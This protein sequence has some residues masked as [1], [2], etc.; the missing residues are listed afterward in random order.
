MYFY[1]KQSHFKTLLSRFY[2]SKKLFPIDLDWYIP[3]E[4]LLPVGVYHCQTIY[5]RYLSIKKNRARAV[6]KKSYSLVWAEVDRL[7]FFTGFV[8]INFCKVNPSHHGSTC[9]FPDRFT[10]FHS[11]TATRNEVWTNIFPTEMT[12]SSDFKARRRGATGVMD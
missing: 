5:R 9:G 3:E 8:Q 11:P 12:N 6:K 7:S 10:I 2:T 4:F 1:F